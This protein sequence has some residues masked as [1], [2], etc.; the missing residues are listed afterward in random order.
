MFGGKQPTYGTLRDFVQLHNLSLNTMSEWFLPKEHVLY[1]SHKRFLRN[2]TVTDLISSCKTLKICPGTNSK[3]LCGDLIVH[4]I[5]NK[6]IANI[7]LLIL[8]MR[9]RSYRITRHR[10]CEVLV[11]NQLACIACEN[12]DMILNHDT[13]K[14]QKVQNTAAKTKA[15]ISITNPQRIKLTLREQKLK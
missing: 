2:A 3:E 4:S 1:K 9:T 10:Y 8:R 12:F 13:R 11:K 5:P 6:Y 15:P 7:S 14:K